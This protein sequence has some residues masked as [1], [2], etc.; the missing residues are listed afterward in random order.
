ML[1][2]QKFTIFINLHGIKFHK[3]E[4]SEFAAEVNCHEK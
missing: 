3:K 2:I 4:T 1:F